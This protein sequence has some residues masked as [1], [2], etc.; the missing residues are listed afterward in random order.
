M[1][2][3][4][5]SFFKGALLPNLKKFAEREFLTMGVQRLETILVIPRANIGACVNMSGL[6]AKDFSAERRTW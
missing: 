1:R 6:G 3:R 2:L 4:F 5:L